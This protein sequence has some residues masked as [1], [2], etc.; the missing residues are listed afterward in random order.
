MGDQ[1]REL[2]EIFKREGLS[3]DESASLLEGKVVLN[4]DAQRWNQAERSLSHGYVFSPESDLDGGPAN[5][6][7]D[8]DILA[9]YHG[10]S[11]GEARR[12]VGTYTSIVLE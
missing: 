1:V 7:T 9:R 2:I 8:G 10:R 6:V 5:L 4:L 11:L 3:V 12:Y